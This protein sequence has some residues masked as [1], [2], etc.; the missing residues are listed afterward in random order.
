MYKSETEKCVY[1]KALYLKRSISLNKSYFVHRYHAQKS[2]IKVLY[3]RTIALQADI[4]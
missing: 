4:F 1:M 2:I 3:L